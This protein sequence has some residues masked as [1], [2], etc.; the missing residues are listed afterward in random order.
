MNTSS[1]EYI[2]KISSTLFIF[3]WFWI[4]TSFRKC[5]QR[6]KKKGKIKCWSGFWEGDLALN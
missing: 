5:W 4:N 6:M 3:F 2:H 1:D